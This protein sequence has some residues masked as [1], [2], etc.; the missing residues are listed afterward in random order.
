MQAEIG[1]DWE[2]TRVL[3]LLLSFSLRSGQRENR[4]RFS[5]FN[6]VRL[7][8][9]LSGVPGQRIIPLRHIFLCCQQNIVLLQVVLPLIQQLLIAPCLPLAVQRGVSW[10]H[11]ALHLSKNISRCSFW[12]L[13]WVIPT[14][15]EC[16]TP[17]HYSREQREMSVS[18][19]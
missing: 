12:R 9:H 18:R 7:K 2:R 17:L 5:P 1:R 4:C 6:T 19:S 15:F 14:V 8:V 13:C 3:S 10:W 16:R 11:R